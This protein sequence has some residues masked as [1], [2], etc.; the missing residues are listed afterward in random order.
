MEQSIEVKGELETRLKD[1]DIEAYIKGVR[2]RDRIFEAVGMIAT[3]LVLLFL[4]AIAV[5]LLID[6]WVR[7]KDPGFYTSYPSRFPEQAGILSSWVGTVYVM[8]GAI[9]WAVVLGIP[10]G[11]YLEEY[12]GKG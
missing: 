3:F 4:F 6:G 10:A 11:I 1:F 7:I 8:L 5:D 9:F 12:G 2:K